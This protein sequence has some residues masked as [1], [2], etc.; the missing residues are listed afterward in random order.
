[1]KLR[2]RK[3]IATAGGIFFFYRWICVGSIG[4]DVLALTDTWISCHC[5]LRRGF[6]M[7]KWREISS[8][9]KNFPSVAKIPLFFGGGGAVSFQLTIQRWFAFEQIRTFAFWAAT[10]KAQSLSLSSFFRMKTTTGIFIFFFS[11][12]RVEDFRHFFVW[13]LTLHSWK[14][15]V[16]SQDFRR[17]SFC[18]SFVTST[19]R[20]EKE[21]LCARSCLYVWRACVAFPLL[22]RAGFF[23]ESQ[24]R[25]EI[26]RSRSSKETRPWATTRAYRSLYSRKRQLYFGWVSK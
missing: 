9:F 11:G 22:Y 14:S 26:D 13:N 4:I 2:W 25:E 16:Y 10:K 19:R 8:S 15:Y 7:Y 18:V 24:K 20:R 12:V 6:S 1:M 3:K 23:E 5:S 21:A 17:N